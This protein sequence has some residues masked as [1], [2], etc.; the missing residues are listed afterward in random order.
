MEKKK[1]KFWKKAL[2]VL[3]ILIIIFLL[4]IISHK[5]YLYIDINNRYKEFE[6]VETIETNGTLTYLEDESCAKVDN[7][8]YI[9]QDGIGIK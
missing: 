7:M 6:K 2:I 3:A 5:V 9:V 1:M 8:D 4:A